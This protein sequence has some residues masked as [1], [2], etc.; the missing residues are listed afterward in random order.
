MLN[1]NFKRSKL[2]RQ[3]ERLNATDNARVTV[4]CYRERRRSN[5]ER[6]DVQILNTYAYERSESRNLNAS[7]RSARLS[8]N[9]W[10]RQPVATDTEWLM[11][12]Y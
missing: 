10:T 8:Q 7:K 2:E 11:L 4:F 5:A 3:I 9:A 12:F 1:T 6:A